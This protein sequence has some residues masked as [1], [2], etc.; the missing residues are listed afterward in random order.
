[1]DPASPS[2]RWEAR[3]HHLTL[4]HGNVRTRTPVTAHVLGSGA[5]LR[6]SA[7]L[8]FGRSCLRFFPQYGNWEPAL[9]NR[10]R[11]SG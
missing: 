4:I 2:A 11:K 9:H 8:L 1:M 6:Y 10:L 7:F 3:G 5:L